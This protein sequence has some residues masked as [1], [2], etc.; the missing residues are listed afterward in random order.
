MTN[1]LS[2][3][4]LAEQLAT[5]HADVVGATAITP[6]IYKA[7]RALQIAKDVNPDAVTVLGGI[8]ATFMYRQ[9]LSEAP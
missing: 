7:E 3:D 8:H 9:V 4:E 1:D 5:A 2:D 6:S